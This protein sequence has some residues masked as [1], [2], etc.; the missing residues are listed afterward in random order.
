MIDVANEF[1]VPS[2]GYYY[3]SGA[4]N[5]AFTI[6][7]EQLYTQNNS[8]NVKM[9]SSWL[10]NQVPSKVISGLYLI[11]EVAVWIH[12]QTKRLRTEMKGILINTF[13]ELESHVIY[14]L[15]TDSSL[16]LPPLYSVGPVLHLKKNI[17]TMDRVDVLKWLDDQPPPSV[18]FLC[19]G[20]RGSF[21]K[22][23]VEE[24]G[25]ALF[26]L[27]PPPTVGTKWDENSNRLY[28]L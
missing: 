27:V 3:T 14:S 17:E 18:V 24:I 19:F 4:G 15:S 7:L 22:D 23:Q 26:H 13:E 9:S 16:Q 8:S 25:R 11:N 12:A 28:K 1:E 5:L 10:V 2:Y 20:S 21:E 6:L